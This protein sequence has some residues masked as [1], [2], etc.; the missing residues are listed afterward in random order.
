M[1][2]GFKIHVIHDELVLQ[3]FKCLEETNLPEWMTERKTTQ[4]QRDSQ[5]E[6]SQAIMDRLGIYNGEDLLF[7]CAL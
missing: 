7:F 4:V 6:P 5:K 2:S 3:Q 1:D